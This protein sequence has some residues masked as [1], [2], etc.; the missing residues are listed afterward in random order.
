MAGETSVGGH[1]SIRRSSLGIPGQ[2]REIN[3][4]IEPRAAG[5]GQRRDFIVS[6]QI[7]VDVDPRPNI[8]HEKSKPRSARQDRCAKTLR[9]QVRMPSW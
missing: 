3:S 2:S 7:D 9:R 1:P 8:C 5:S 6:E 4:R